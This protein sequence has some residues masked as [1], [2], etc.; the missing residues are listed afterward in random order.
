MYDALALAK[1]QLDAFVA[2]NPAAAAGGCKKRILCL[3]D[4]CDTGLD[5][6]DLIVHTWIHLMTHP[7]TDPLIHL[8]THGQHILSHP[9]PLTFWLYRIA[10]SP[11]QAQKPM[12]WLESPSCSG[13]AE[14]SWTASPWAK[15][16]TT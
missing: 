3:S 14:S 13:Q 2:S 15:K 7:L 4:G 16:T 6:F 9:S 10:T 12:T 1:N 5:A 11:L 8:S